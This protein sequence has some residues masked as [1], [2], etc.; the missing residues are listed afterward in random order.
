MSRTP[1]T[2]LFRLQ[3]R[4]LLLRG[5]LIHKTLLLGLSKRWNVQYGNSFSTQVHDLD[6]LGVSNTFNKFVIR[7]QQRRFELV[8]TADAI[9]FEASRHL[10][11]STQLHD[12]DELEVELGSTA[13]ASLVLNS[14]P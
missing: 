13:D 6:E 7:L 2:S 4:P 14:A 10:S 9:T 1:S 11:F 8:S 3:Q 12:L 5:L